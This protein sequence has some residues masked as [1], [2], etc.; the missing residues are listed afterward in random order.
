MNLHDIRMRVATP[1]DAAA[2]LNIYA[3]YVQNTA[4]TFEY[5]VPTTE[6][7]ARRISSFGSD[8]PF[9]VAEKPIEAVTVTNPH[10][11]F[12][13]S[14]ASISGNTTTP[15]TQILGY[16][17]AHPYYGYAA[18]SWCAE[19]TIYVA[20]EAR[21]QKVGTLLYDTL[22]DALGRMGILNV[23]ACITTSDDALDP[24]VPVAS[25]HFHASR[26]YRIIGT[27]EKCGYKFNRW[28]NTV[29][30]QKTLGSHQD[31]MSTP[32][33]FANVRGSLSWLVQ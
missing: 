12:A 17:Y 15:A 1:N 6:E 33:S 27:F 28:Y 18:Y 3:P 31:D 25:V 29:W 8:F 2:L 5:E 22:E 19:L 20:P 21:H 4:I 24:R 16:A 11:A 7:Y 13:F 23:Y 14:S 9:L 10:D 32:H 26:G 30:M